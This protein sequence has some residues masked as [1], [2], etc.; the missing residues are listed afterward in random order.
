MKSKNLDAA[1]AVSWILDKSEPIKTAA[2]KAG[3]IEP[4]KAPRSFESLEK[5]VS[6]IRVAGYSISKT[7][8]YD[9]HHCVV[10][11]EEVAPAEGEKRKKSI[12]PIHQADDGKWYVSNTFRWWMTS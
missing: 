4:D 7:F 10:R 1:A 6:S 12:R 11:L 9:D 2:P 3:E 5:A 8:V